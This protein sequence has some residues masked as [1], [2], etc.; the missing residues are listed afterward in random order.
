MKYI[1][2]GLGNFGSTLSVSLTDMGHEVIGV[3]RD[4][5]KVNALKDKITHAVC[6]DA[7]SFES[8]NTLPLQD[9]DAVIVGIGEDFG[10]SVMATALLKQLKVKKLISRSM[11]E[12]HRTVIDAIG[13]NQIIN[14]E[15]ESALRLAKKMQIKGV[16]DSFELSDRFSIIEAKVPDEFIGKTVEEVG[17]AGRYGVNLLTILKMRESKNLFGQAK[18][19]PEVASIVHPS[20][21]LESNDILVLFGKPENIKECLRE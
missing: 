20:T 7:T 8:I 21:I 10:A 5:N 6:V 3:D 14:P 11:S 16:V 2:I 13:V 17:F 9:A 1:I 12:L 19:K 18:L 15:E 4:M